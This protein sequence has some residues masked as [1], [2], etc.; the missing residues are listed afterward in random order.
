MYRVCHLIRGNLSLLKFALGGCGTFYAI[1]IKSA[2]F[3]GM[4]TLK[5]HRLVTEELK[6]EVANIHGL[7][8][9]AANGLGLAH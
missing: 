1:A 2:A 8:V 5:Q 9:R 4:T 3:S 7:Q 6:D